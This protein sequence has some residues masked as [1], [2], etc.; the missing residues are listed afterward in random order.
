MNNEEKGMSLIV[1][2]VTRWLKG[3]IFL[4][5]AY[6]VVFGHLSP[7]GGFPGGVV[8][9]ATFILIT[10]AF[11]REYA[12]KKIGKILA[13]ELDSLGALLFLIIA[14]LGIYFT[15]IFFSNFIEKFHP[16]G[17]FKL[18]SSGTIPLC[19]ISIGIKV[20]A[21]LF[22]IFIILSIVR[23]VF[24]D[25]KGKLITTEKKREK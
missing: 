9:A 3:F 20:G 23:V 24:E 10:L 11:G 14:T 13:S 18:F 5:G 1:K 16:T 12:L 2:T 25:G 15:G 22:M 8:F 7:G 17:N 19:N 6:I 21:S 4:F